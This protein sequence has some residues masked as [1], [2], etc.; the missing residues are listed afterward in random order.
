MQQATPAGTTTSASPNAC[1]SA[2]AEAEAQLRVETDQSGQRQ[3]TDEQP[4]SRRDNTRT[5]VSPLRASGGRALKSDSGADN[6]TVP[7]NLKDEVSLAAAGVVERVLAHL[8]GRVYSPRIKLLDIAQVGEA[9]G[10]AS[11][12][13]YQ[14]VAEGDFPAPVKIGR[15]NKWRESTLIAWLDR[16]EGNLEG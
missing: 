7:R 4:S 2:R 9:T 6:G 14:L 11:S 12:T 13:I 1:S 3:R 8:C 15:Q 16:R 5:P 10:L